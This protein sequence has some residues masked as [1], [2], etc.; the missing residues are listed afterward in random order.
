[1]K[2]KDVEVRQVFN[3]DNTPSYPKIKTMTGY[4][5]IRDNIGNFSGNCDDYLAEIMSLE[6][7]AKNYEGTVEEI[8]E[9]I[10]KQTSIKPN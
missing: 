10:V 3:I 1:M 9:W 4:I 6:L 2:V 7:L 5:D 8:T